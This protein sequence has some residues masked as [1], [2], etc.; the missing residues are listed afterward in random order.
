MQVWFSFRVFQVARYESLRVLQKY[1]FGGP[2]VDDCRR[3]CHCRGHGGIDLDGND[4]LRAGP[5]GRFEFLNGVLVL[6]HS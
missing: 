4:A 6:L 2:V 1:R 5:R 3:V